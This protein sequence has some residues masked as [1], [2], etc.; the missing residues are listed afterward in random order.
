[1]SVMLRSKRAIRRVTL[2][3]QLVQRL[4]EDIW[5]GKLI[6]NAQLNE[7]EL[8]LTFGVSRGPLREAM[9][10]LIQ[11]GLLRSDPHRGVFV[12]EI[13]EADLKDIYFVRGAIETAAIKQIITSGNTVRISDQ[14][15]GISERMEKAVSAKS[16]KA[17]SELDF[18][19]HR[20][21]VDGAN[22]KR[23]AKTYTTVQAETR[24]CLHRLM[25]GYR[26]STDMAVEHFEF[27]NILKNGDLTETTEELKKHFGDPVAIM[28]RAKQNISKEKIES[29]SE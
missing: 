23:L 29:F 20:T 18:E 16:W 25:A 3:E 14:L 15:L 17:G 21:L 1:M 5:T 6:S 13:G 27:A 4:R 28:Q 19:F 10:R 8:A 26:C 24:L 22:S 11:E 9:Q 12:E 7:R 2:S